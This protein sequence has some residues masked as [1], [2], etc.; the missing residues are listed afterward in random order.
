MSAHWSVDS[1]KTFRAFEV[2]LSWRVAR[3]RSP[4]IFMDVTHV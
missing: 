4:V 1:C 2:T 3:K